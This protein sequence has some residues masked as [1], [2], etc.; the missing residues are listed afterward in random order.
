[1]ELLLDLNRA[2][3]IITGI[4]T[5]VAG[6]VAI[7]YNFR[8]PKNHRLAGQIFFWAMMHVTLSAMVGFWR[9]PEQPF[10]QFLGLLAMMVL[11][12][13]V[14]GVRAMQ[15]YKG[16]TPFWLDRAVL[17]GHFAVGLAMLALAGFY[18]LKWQNALPIAILLTIFGSMTAAGGFAFQKIL[19]HFSTVDRRHFYKLHLTSM[20]GG[21]TASTTAFVVQTCHFLPWWLQFFGPTM[22]L[23]PVTFYFLNTLNLR[24]KDLPKIE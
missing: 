18:F 6:P 7:F 22:V 24:K 10:Y 3:H 2:L 17:F 12:G 11:V 20:L 4:S 5:L 16:K 9:R 21:F 8:N 15:I 19:R 14:L 1:M 13:T 23:L